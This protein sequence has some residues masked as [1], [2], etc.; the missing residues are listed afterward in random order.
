MPRELVLV[1]GGARAGKSSYAQRLA[2]AG[3]KVLFV[4]TAEP[5]DPEMAARIEAHRA[6]RPRQWST[7]E[8]PTELV[9]ALAPM[10]ERYDTVLLDC[11]TLWVSNLLL[12]YES[13]EVEPYTLRAT[14]A[15]LRLYDRGAATWIIVSNEVGNGVV[16]GTPL[17]R[18]YRDLLGQVNQVVAQGADRVF[19][20][21]AGLPLQ[22]KGPGGPALG[23]APG[24]GGP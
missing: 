7:T 9:F 16:P 22:I 23:A 8:E 21:T 18:R 14:E 2:S 13:T 24:L 5:R 3:T 1:L 15:L 17:G 4:A 11:L 12:K 6:Q 19:L 10:V 20:M